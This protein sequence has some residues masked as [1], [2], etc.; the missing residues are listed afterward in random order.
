MGRARGRPRGGGGEG[1]YRN[2]R[3]VQISTLERPQDAVHVLSDWAFFGRLSY[4]YHVSAVGLATFRE[5]RNGL[6]V[7]LLSILQCI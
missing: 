6:S 5:M 2:E 4:W 3:H 1:E 7:S